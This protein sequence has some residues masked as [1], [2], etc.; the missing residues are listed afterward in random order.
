MLNSKFDYLNLFTYNKHSIADNRSTLSFWTKACLLSQ[1]KVCLCTSVRFKVFMY[2][3]CLG[4]HKIKFRRSQPRTFYLIYF[5]MKGECYRSICANI[6]ALAHAPKYVCSNFF[7]LT[8]FKYQDILCLI[9][10]S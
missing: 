1:S 3:L 2:T 5:Q 6:L 4:E 8:V 7:R 10:L 9:P